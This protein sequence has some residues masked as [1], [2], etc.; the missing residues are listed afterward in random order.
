[1]AA[2]MADVRSDTLIFFDSYIYICNL[3]DIPGVG[4]WYDVAFFC[5]SM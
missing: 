2:A 1:M 4:L 3:L 5:S